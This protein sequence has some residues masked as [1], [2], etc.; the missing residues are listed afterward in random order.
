MNLFIAIVIIVIITVVVVKLVKK[1]DPD[2]IINGM[3]TSA[4]QEN[5]LAQYQ[6]GYYSLLR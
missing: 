4:Q 5:A 3:M 1:S 6:L 2:N